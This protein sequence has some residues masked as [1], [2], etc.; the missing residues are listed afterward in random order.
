[1]GGTGESILEKFVKL[2][3]V[4]TAEHLL[5]FLASERWTRGATYSD[6]VEGYSLATFD[7]PCTSFQ[8]LTAKG[9]GRYAAIGLVPPPARAVGQW[10][11]RVCRWSS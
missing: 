8:A 10:R 4:H 11:R 2:T 9:T 6:Q 1:M 5:V 7:A 3:A